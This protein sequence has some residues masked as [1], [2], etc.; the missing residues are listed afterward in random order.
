M[1]AQIETIEQVK[2]EISIPILTLDISPWCQGEAHRNTSDLKHQVLLIVVL[3]NNP[4]DSMYRSKVPGLEVF[5]RLRGQW[6]RV[7]CPHGSLCSS[8]TSG[9][10]VSNSTLK[11]NSG[12]VDAHQPV[13]SSGSSFR[14]V[15]AFVGEEMQRVCLSNPSPLDHHLTHIM[16]MSHSHQG[17]LSV[18]NT[19]CR[20]SALLSLDSR[21]EY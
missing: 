9:S 19:S 11:T 5:S 17:H 21:L 7:E 2:F 14:E 12:S 16:K 4:N 6:V 20:C 10:A 3:F 15:V 13:K 18:V 1:Y 8:A